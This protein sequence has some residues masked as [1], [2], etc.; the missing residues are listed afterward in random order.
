MLA[1]W[2]AR[3]FQVLNLADRIRDLDV[4]CWLHPSDRNAS[5]VK[6]DV[7]FGEFYSKRQGKNAIK[8][9]RSNTLIRARTPRS[10]SCDR[11]CEEHIACSRL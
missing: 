1:P 11:L 10:R 4:L 7:A 9:T 5:P 8:G 3:D 2:T 6:R